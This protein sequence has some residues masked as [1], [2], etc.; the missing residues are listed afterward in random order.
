MLTP[1]FIRTEGIRSWM[2]QLPRKGPRSF[3]NL[4]VA[5]LY[6]Q[7]S[8]TE[9]SLKAAIRAPVRPQSR[10]PFCPASWNIETS[11]FL[12]LALVAEPTALGKIDA[13]TAD[14]SSSAVLHR[15]G[16]QL[17][18]TLKVPRPSSNTRSRITS[19]SLRGG[20]LLEV[21]VIPRF[22][23]SAVCLIGKGYGTGPLLVGASLIM[24]L[25]SSGVCLARDVAREPKPEPPPA[26]E[27]GP[28]LITVVFTTP[29]QQQFTIWAVPGS[30]VSIFDHESNA[31]YAF[32]VEFAAEP[33]SSIRPG[34][35]RERPRR[36]SISVFAVVP[37]AGGSPYKDIGSS[38]ELRAGEVYVNSTT[39]FL[40]EPKEVDRLSESMTTEVD[41]FKSF[42]CVDCY[43]YSVCGV[44]VSACGGACNNYFKRV[45][46]SPSAVTN[47]TEYFIPEAGRQL[48]N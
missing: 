22:L 15:A 9:A 11:Q 19:Q 12:P 40:F 10:S 5:D 41:G 27:T 29:T 16:T 18:G 48:V 4:E 25:A 28:E 3:P 6:F 2:R 35:E 17:R 23:V 7:H 34:T 38:G 30:L 14:D 26:L 20:H 8:R 43:Y 36:F 33:F 31:E 39:G 21:H 46:A 13:P 24:G 42:C 37:S 45:S 32:Y 44:R 1:F 47:P